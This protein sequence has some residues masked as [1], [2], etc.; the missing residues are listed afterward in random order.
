MP[1]YR[2]TT[3]WL[4]HWF[5]FL[6][7]SYSRCLI[8][9]EATRQLRFS[10]ANEWTQTQ[11]R[12]NL[13]TLTYAIPAES[14]ARV[15]V[16]HEPPG[17]PQWVW[18]DTE[19]SFHCTITP[20]YPP[21]KHNT[22]RTVGNCSFWKSTQKKQSTGHDKPSKGTTQSQQASRNSD[23]EKGSL[24]P[25]EEGTQGSTWRDLSRRV[26]RSRRSQRPFLRA[27]KGWNK[28]QANLN[29]VP[30]V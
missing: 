25:R 16:L 20:G 13:R 23:M 29:S 18:W 6:P 15:L 7:C 8:Y 14:I 4:T 27:Y 21:Q 26:D 2:H 22:M 12:Q 5:S 30:P 24:W 17:F 10:K 28:R 1:P 9:K 11:Y 19:R 3:H